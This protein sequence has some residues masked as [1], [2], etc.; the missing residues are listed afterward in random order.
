MN[1]GAYSGDQLMDVIRSDVWLV[2]RII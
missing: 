1:L 2:M